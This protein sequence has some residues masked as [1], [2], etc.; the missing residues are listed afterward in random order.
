VRDVA[1]WRGRFPAHRAHPLEGSLLVLSR[2]PLSQVAVHDLGRRGHL[3]VARTTLDGRALEL[4]VV[5]FPSDPTAVRRPF[6]QHPELLRPV[7]PGA[8]RVV[9]GDFNTPRD[10]VWFAAYDGLYTHAF[11]AAG[12]G[13]RPTWPAWFPVVDLDHVWVAG[14]AD[15]GCSF[16]VR[17]GLSDH[18][19][20]VADLD[21]PA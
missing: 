21:W 3:A 7:A 4:A 11:D 16:V 18:R 15:I 14:A 6:V 9:L 19:P 10:S 2:Q 5:D 17:T 20:V 13:W 1:F 8:A 12:R